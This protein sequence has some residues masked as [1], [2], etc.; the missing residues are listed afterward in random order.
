MKKIKKNITDNKNATVK[1]EQ[2]IE[3]LSL[4]LENNPCIKE[5]VGFEDNWKKY[6]GSGGYV[7]GIKYSL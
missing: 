6:G 2:A 4:K 1:N 3:D 5:C 7:D